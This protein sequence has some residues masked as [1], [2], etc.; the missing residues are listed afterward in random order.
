MKCIECNKETISLKK[1]CE[2]CN[3]ELKTYDPAKDNRP[4]Y[5]ADYSKVIGVV[6]VILSIAKV[7]LRLYR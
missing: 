1:Y 5:K 3:A 2:H 6:I 4:R 7:I